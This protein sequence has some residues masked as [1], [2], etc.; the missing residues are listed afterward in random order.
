MLYFLCRK[1]TKDD[2]CS[3]YAALC[4]QRALGSEAK[5]EAGESPARSRHCIDGALSVYATA[6][7]KHLG[8]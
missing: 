5:M 6:C 1:L 8:R 7:S 3:S 4:G 2:L